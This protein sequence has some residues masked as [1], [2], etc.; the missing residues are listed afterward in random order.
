M[1]VTVPVNMRKFYDSTTLRNFSSYINPGIDPRYGDYTLDEIIMLTHHYMRYEITE[2]H[3][4]A[5]LA[6]N[7]QSERNILMRVMPLFMKNFALM[8]IFKLVGESRFTSTMTNMGTVDVPEEMK[9]HVEYFEA[10]LGPSLYNK[11]NC[12]VTSYGKTLCVSFT[13][14]IKESYVERE[15]FSLLVRQGI[16]VKVFS[17]QE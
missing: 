12:A 5:R 14:T 16:P 4:N 8:M 6:K 15:F 2:K 1:K 3:L 17:N 9:P 7:V 10:Q 11:V 13:R